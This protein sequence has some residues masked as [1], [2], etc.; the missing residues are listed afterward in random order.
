M[1]SP[2]RKDYR[3]APH[4]ITQSLGEP[5][6]EG[7]QWFAA[8]G[9]RAISTNGLPMSVSGIYAFAS[10]D[11]KRGYTGHEHAD[12]IGLIH[13]NGRMYDPMVGRFI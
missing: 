11:G 3:T 9:K 13:M 8:F 2:T 1:Y 5:A 12:A 7:Q 4:R 6:S 10:Q